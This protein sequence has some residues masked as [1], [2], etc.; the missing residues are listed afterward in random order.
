MAKRHQRL[1]WDARYKGNPK[2]KRYKK[3]CAIAHGAAHQLCCCCLIRPSNVI[4]HSRYGKDEIGLTVFPVCGGRYD[5]QGNLKPGEKAGCHEL[6]CHH[7]NNWVTYKNSPLWKNHN[8]L[9]FEKRLRLGYI[10]L[11]KGVRHTAKPR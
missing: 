8:T 2:G 1:N 3:M 11:N 6:L 9:K 5:D 4:H 7:P 10:L